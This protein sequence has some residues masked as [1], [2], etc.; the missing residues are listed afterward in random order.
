MKTPKWALWMKTTAARG[1]LVTA[2]W[3]DLER[4]KDVPSRT[5]AMFWAGQYAVDPAA[6]ATARQLAQAAGYALVDPRLTVPR[7][8]AQRQLLANAALATPEWGLRAWASGAVG[9]APGWELT[10]RQLIAGAPERAS[11]G[12]GALLVGLAAVGALLL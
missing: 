10:A 3:R 5:R 4:H 1:P 6:E 7:T 8:D 9:V 2:A 12:A 11:V